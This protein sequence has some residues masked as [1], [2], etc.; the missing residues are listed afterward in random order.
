MT[1]SI[2]NRIKN[3]WLWRQKFHYL[4]N[5]GISEGLISDFLSFEKIKRLKNQFIGSGDNSQL[6][7]KCYCYKVQTLGYFSEAFS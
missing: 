3:E 7:F 4:N 5:A 2:G 1:I 6:I